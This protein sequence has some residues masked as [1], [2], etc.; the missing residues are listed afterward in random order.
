MYNTYIHTYVYILYMNI[1]KHKWDDTVH[2]FFKT[3]IID[4]FSWQ[5]L[6]TSKFFL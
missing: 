1:D 6:N 4:N 5:Y 3:Y 2:L